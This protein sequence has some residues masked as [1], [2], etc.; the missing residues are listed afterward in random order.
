M[1]LPLTLTELQ[2]RAAAGESFDYLCFWGHRRRADA[3]VSASCFSQ[4][5]P[6][7]F[8]VDAVAYAS[9][10]HFMMAEKARLFDDAATRAKI[11]A[12]PT[13]DDAKRL[14]RQVANYDDA[15]W[16][17]RRFDAVVRGNLAKFAADDAL[18]RF[19]LGTASRVLVEAS[20][21]DTVWGIG[22]AAEDPRAADPA[23]WQ[24]LNLLG[25]ALMVVRGRLAA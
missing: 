2:T 22:L 13:P 25:F 6:T 21:I 16:A 11:L 14:G 17:A 18:R 20:P 9:A 24:G 23:Q 15:R 5:Y 12:A 3:A 19:L 1:T 8:E 10:E 4:W 7:R